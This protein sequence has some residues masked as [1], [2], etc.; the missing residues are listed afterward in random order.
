MCWLA[1]F[2]DIWG[3]TC[4]FWAV[5]E[6]KSCNYHKR[7]WIAQGMATESGVL[8]KLLHRLRPWFEASDKITY[9]FW[10]HFVGMVTL[11]Y[12]GFCLMN[13]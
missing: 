8:S 11:R 10:Y 4:D 13:F 1:G 7:M 3:L 5:F 6:E 2:P 9:R 12:A